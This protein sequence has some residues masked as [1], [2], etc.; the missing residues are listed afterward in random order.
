MFYKTELT[1]PNIINTNLN[2]WENSRF[3]LN[4]RATII[5][6]TTID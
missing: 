4:T 6:T 2:W 3:D 5:T 1:K